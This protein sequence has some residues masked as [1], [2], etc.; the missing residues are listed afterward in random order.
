M[1]VLAGSARADEGSPLPDT[2]I[3][4]AVRDHTTG[5]VW[6]D[7]AQFRN[8]Q[9]S[10]FKVLASMTTFVAARDAGRAVNDGEK[11][12]M[13]AALEYSDNE[14][15]DALWAGFGRG[16]F[17][18]DAMRRLGLPGIRRAP[19]FAWGRVTAT[20]PD[21]LQ[22]LSVLEKGR[23]GVLAPSEGAWIRDRM[24]ESTVIWGVGAPGRD[25]NRRIEVKNG[26]STFDDTEDR[27]VLNSLGTVTETL[28]G[29]R[30]ARYSMS[31]QSFG[32]QSV[33]EGSAV[34]DQIGLMVHQA[35]TC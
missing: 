8:R 29:G 11:E 21:L 26:W 33:E 2:G 9:A 31:L 27:W 19:G 18:D 4:I 16:P 1:S 35:L 34:L 20:C 15:T 12:L 13:E 25:A 32:F 28:P 17:F 7:N 5:R 10:V 23:S 22:A 24:N 30:R 6:S 3:G 14:A